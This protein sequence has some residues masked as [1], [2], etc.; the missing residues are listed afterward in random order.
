[1]TDQGEE[2]ADEMRLGPGPTAVPAEQRNE[3]FSMYALGHNCTNP[4]YS[5]CL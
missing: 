1:M 5:L 4:Q 3:A 2:G